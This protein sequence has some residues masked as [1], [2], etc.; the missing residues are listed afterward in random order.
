M[1]RQFLFALLFIAAGTCQ[2]A[3]AED[4]S[5]Q[6]QYGHWP[7]TEEQKAADQEFIASAAA[8]FDG[9]RTLAAEQLAEIGW[10]LFKQGNSPQAMRRFNEAWLLDNDN[11][12]ALWGMGAVSQ[13][14]RLWGQALALY[15]Q[16]KRTQSDKLDF[17]IDYAR[18]LG[19][20]ALQRRTVGGAMPVTRTGQGG[21]RLLAEKR[22]GLL[23]EA[24]SLY[25]KNYEKAPENILNLQYWAILLYSIGDYAQAWD[26]IKLAEASPQ[27]RGISQKFMNLL[28]EKMPRP[29]SARTLP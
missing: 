17:S 2:L 21:A 6:P 3:H 8:R 4:I 1:I 12:R 11:G 15:D 18:T 5:L 28:Q 20:A 7:K 29:D 16:A 9:N 25:A 23:Q 14:A 27:H 19:N 13:R 26:K 10:Q 22:S 24:L